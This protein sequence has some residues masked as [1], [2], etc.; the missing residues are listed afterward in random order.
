MGA[1]NRDQNLK[2][3]ETLVL[4]KYVEEAAAAALEGLGRCKT[5][6][7]VWSAVE[8]RTEVWLG[9][10][11]AAEAVSLPGHLCLAPSVP[12]VVHTTSPKRTRSRLDTTGKSDACYTPS[13]SERER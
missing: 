12:D 9:A 1:E 10:L 5:E 13:R 7:D 2:D 3:I 6:K 4:E 11:R 8:V